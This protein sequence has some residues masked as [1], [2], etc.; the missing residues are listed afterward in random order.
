MLLSLPPLLSNINEY[1][2]LGE[3]KRNRSIFRSVFHVQELVYVPV[4]AANLKPAGQAGRLDTQ[5][6][7]DD[8]S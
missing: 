8:A 1:T 7:V 5:V 4:G 6:E 2:S 3:D